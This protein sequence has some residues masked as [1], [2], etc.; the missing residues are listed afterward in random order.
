MEAIANGQKRMEEFVV[1][2]STGGAIGGIAALVLSIIGLAG[3]MP[4]YMLVIS[5]I[6]LGTGM[7]K[8]QVGI[9]SKPVTR[10]RLF[11]ATF[12][13]ALRPHTWWDPKRGS[14]RS[15]REAPTPAGSRSGKSRR[16]RR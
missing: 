3:V 15:P 4:T 9:T 12:R 8:V 10:L 7:L 13:Q 2:G 11:S 6:V 1:G 5:A 16:S 14:S